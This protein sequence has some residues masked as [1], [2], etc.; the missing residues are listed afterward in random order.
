MNKSKFKFLCTHCNT[1]GEFFPN[2]KWCPECGGRL[3]RADRCLICQQDRADPETGKCDYCTEILE[4]LQPF[5]E[6]RSEA[7][8]GGWPFVEPGDAYI[9]QRIINSIVAAK[10]G[11][12]PDGDYPIVVKVID[13]T[14]FQW[15]G[16]MIPYPE[17]ADSLNQLISALNVASS[18]LESNVNGFKEIVRVIETRLKAGVGEVIGVQHK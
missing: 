3:I 1:P 5:L 16:A 10:W 6:N 7:K 15:F 4:H 12:D 9:L 11:T 18:S 2:K 17:Q 13:R 14:R 8:D